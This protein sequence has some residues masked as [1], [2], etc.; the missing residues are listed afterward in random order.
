MYAIRSYYGMSVTQL[1]QVIDQAARRIVD[2][3][4]GFPILATDQW[5]QAASD[6]LAQFYTP[7]IDR[8]TSYNVCYTKLLRS[9]CCA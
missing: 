2:V 6:L 9:G 5:Q 8:I 4:A 1:A 3:G 7:L